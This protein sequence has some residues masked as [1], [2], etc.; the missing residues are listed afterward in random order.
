MVIWQLIS[1]QKR[2]IWENF[3]NVEENAIF[4]TN[5]NDFIAM[6]FTAMLGFDWNANGMAFE[7]TLQ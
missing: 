5:L 2:K 1:L 6:H 3:V 4:K 7:A